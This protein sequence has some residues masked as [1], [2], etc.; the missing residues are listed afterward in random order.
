MI[1]IIVKGRPASYNSSSTNKRRWRNLVAAE[2]TSACSAPSSCELE[3]N[4][5]FFYRAVLDFDTD[6]MSKPTIDALKG[7]AFLDDRQV[8]KRSVTAVDLNGSFR[9]VD[10]DPRVSAAI[11]DGVDFVSI[12]IREADMKAVNL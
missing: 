12:T 2:A 4:V 3:V 9:I 11:T 10:P 6:N 7:I 1:L 8:K 5:T